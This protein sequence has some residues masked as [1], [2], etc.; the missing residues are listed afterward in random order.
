MPF[1]C[2][3]RNP[4]APGRW[5]QAQVELARRCH[6]QLS[7]GCSVET[8][9][10]R[11][12]SGRGRLWGTLFFRKRA[13]SSPHRA[14]IFR[15]RRRTEHLLH[16]AVA[17]AALPPRRSCWHVT[18]GAVHRCATQCSCHGGPRRCGT[19]PLVRVAGRVRK[20]GV[21]GVAGRGARNCYVNCWGGAAPSTTRATTR[22]GPFPAR[23]LHATCK[24]CGQPQAASRLT[25]PQP[26]ADST[27]AAP[28]ILSRLVA[29]SCCVARSA[30]RYMHP[31]CSQPPRACLPTAVQVRP[32]RPRTRTCSAHGARH[33]PRTPCPPP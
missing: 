21:R 27:P 14:R 11:G 26:R 13:A 33:R 18:L 32:R 3:R 16:H 20:G 17:A 9:K 10:A 24:L 1:A 30:N 31:P 19:L 15:H 12:Q 22:Q 6:A 28:V 2:T 29:F 4:T 8:H 23:E 25:P 7:T 5:R